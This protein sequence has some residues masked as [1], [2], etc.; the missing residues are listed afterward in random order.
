MQRFL[1]HVTVAT[2][3]VRDDKFLFV[4]ESPDGRTVINQPAGHLEKGESLEQAAVRECLEETAWDVKL[5]GFLGVTVYYS[6]ANGITYI[7]NTFVAEPIKHHPE[8]RLDSGIDAA[9]WL[10]A[11]EIEDKRELLRSP[12]VLDAV[13]RYQNGDILP[14]SAVSN[15]GLDHGSPGP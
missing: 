14:L 15:F 4:E 7:R 3:V 13:K 6:S 11:R 10:T 5:T 2:V 1:P 12:L 9:I 8:Q